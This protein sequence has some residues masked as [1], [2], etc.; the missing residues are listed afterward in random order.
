MSL[1]DLAVSLGGRLMYSLTTN[2]LG[3]HRL[4]STSTQRNS[5]MGRFPRT[6]S[7]FHEDL[8][9][10]FNSHRRE[11]ETQEITRAPDQKGP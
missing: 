10:V 6:Q 5:L 9:A 8:K 11:V 7:F 4:E 3:E 2:D 1:W